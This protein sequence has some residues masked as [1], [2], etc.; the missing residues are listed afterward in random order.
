MITAVGSLDDERLAAYASLTDLQLRSRLEPSRGMFIAESGKV[1]SRALDAG[2][3]IVSLL[4]PEHRVERES[5]LITRI[6]ELE[7][8]HGRDIP[9]FVA[10][11]SELRRLAGYELT[12]GVLGAMKR[13]PE[14]PASQLLAGASRVAVLEDITNHANVGSVFRNAA[15]F[16]LDAV[17][18]TP[19]CSDPLY[20]RAARV[21]MGNVFNVPWTRIGDSAGSWVEDGFATLREAGFTTVAMALADNAIE[22][23]DPRLKRVEKLA[24][25][26]GSEGPG[27][28]RRALAQCDFVVKIPMSNGV[29][30]LNV[31][32]ASAVAFWE[33]R[34]RPTGPCANTECFDTTPLPRR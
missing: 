1:V 17:L 14:P 30:S 9:V 20:R 11:V 29:D 24:V 33:L 3:E 2:F 22:L 19:G 21:S 23:D 18:V 34:R 15:A 13:K 25:L 31:A 10:P 8:S 4:V 26:L 27:L 5:D 16:G 28:S 7:K 12:R 32:A 6:S